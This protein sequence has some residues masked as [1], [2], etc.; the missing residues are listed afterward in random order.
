MKQ[1]IKHSNPTIKKKDLENVLNCLITDEIARG[2][3]V[4]EFEQKLIQ[5]LGVKHGISVSSGEAAL[6]MILLALQLE[7]G[8]EIII[9]SYYYTTTLNVIYYVNAV[10]VLADID[11][12]NYNISFES[13]Q[14]KITEKTKAVIVPHLFGLP[15]DIKPFLSLN[16][17]I[18]EDCGHS[19]G[20]QIYE[21][22]VREAGDITTGTKTGSFGD[23]SFFSFYATR[24]I[25]TGQGGFIG[26]KYKKDFDFISDLLQYDERDDYKVRYP[27]LLS[28][29]QAALGIRQI[30]LLD[31]FINVRREIASIFNRKLLEVNR[32]I[33]EDSPERVN[34]Y[35]RYPVKVNIPTKEAI[36]LYKNQGVQVKR[37]VYKP[38]H[39]YLKMDYNEFPNSEEAFKTL[40]SVPIYPTLQ[41]SQV[42][43]LA[44]VISKI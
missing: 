37:P 35:Y 11:I 15:V 23:F 14:S 9:P 20:A 32:Q 21:T 5:Y 40:I 4:N 36:E 2:N 26:C 3:L 17:P 43:L 22:E 29:M 44:K 41:K 19:I 28:D 31:Y 16:I 38:L 27:Y 6:H 24:M 18:I 30:D 25:T 8:D 42:E 34:V 39:Q 33:P 10:P 13:V 12:N 7:P 1:L